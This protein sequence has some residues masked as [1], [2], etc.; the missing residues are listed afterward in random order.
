VVAPRKF[1]GLQAIVGFSF[2]AIAF[3]AS[4][5]HANSSAA[6]IAA[7][8]RAAQDARQAPLNNGDEEFRQL[9]ANWRS[10]DKGVGAGG[11]GYIAP[12]AATA[13]AA[14]TF[15]AGLTLPIAPRR[16]SIPSRV[17]VEG[18][19]LTSDFGMRVHP[20]LG[21][22]RG[23]KGIDL[24][25]PVG[26]PVY[27]TADGVVSRADWFSSYGLYIALE[28]G[29]EI[30]TRYGH[31]SRLNV[32]AGQKVRKGDLIGYVGST[33]RSTGP[34][35]HYEVRLAGAAVNPVPYMQADGFDLQP[36]DQLPRPAFGGTTVAA[37]R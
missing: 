21:V 5:A 14:P 35:L 3:S 11:S 1:A 9:F 13:I 30:Q 7:P 28:H 31:L 37:R 17:P 33:G 18:F 6:D 29:A 20:V 27:A 22:R 2:A 4:P 12:R 15:G 32:I 36:A 24:A 23:H 10:L 16:V 34:H 8:L 25:A 19:R 26:T